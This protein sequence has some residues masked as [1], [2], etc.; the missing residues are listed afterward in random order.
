MPPEP[1]L[2][3][4][5]AEKSDEVFAIF[6]DVKWKVPGLSVAAYKLATSTAVVRTGVPKPKLAPAKRKIDGKMGDL[7]A[8]FKGNLS[9]GSTA[10]V[11][12]SNKPGKTEGSRVHSLILWHYHAKGGKSQI[13]QFTTGALPDEATKDSA[14]RDR[15]WHPTPHI[16]AWRSFSN[17]CSPRGFPDRSLSIEKFPNV[18]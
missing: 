6:P 10:S 14:I 3:M 17:M 4:E 16:N 2:R 5:V 9:D 1:C 7:S 11:N 18:G 12:P 15:L 8:I 13:M